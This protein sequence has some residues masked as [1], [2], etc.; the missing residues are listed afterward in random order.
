MV[1]IKKRN[2]TMTC[3]A[4]QKV[5]IAASVQHV[6]NYW[7]GLFVCIAFLLSISGSTNAQSAGGYIY[8]HEPNLQLIKQQIESGNNWYAE[9]YN[10]LIAESNKILLMDANP[11]T[12]KEY[13][14]PSGN[15]HDYLSIAPYFWPDSSKPD[16]LPWIPQDGVINPLTRG[17]NTDQ[18]RLAKL[19]DAFEHLAFAI[20][21]GNDQ[22]YADKAVS[23]IRIWFIDTATRVNPN[24]NFGQGVPGGKNGNSFGIIEWTGISKA[25]TLM[26]VLEY[27]KLLPAETKTAFAA[28]L[29]EYKDWLITSDLGIKEGRMLQNHGTWYDYQL[30]GILRY[31]GK[32][33]EAKAQAL[34]TQKRIGDQIMPDGSMPKELNRTKSVYYSEMNLRAFTLLSKMCLPLGLD[35]WNYQHQNGSSVQQA[36]HYLRPFANREKMWLYKQ[37]TPGGVDDAIDTRL[38]PLFVIANSLYNLQPLNPALAPEKGLTY[39]QR[40][41]FPF[42]SK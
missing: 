14:P 35:L 29:V 34:I 36:Y 7:L 2:C 26:Q 18:V 8:W 41:E 16:G 20:Y 38:Q 9:A 13:W 11:V 27:K 15:K 37:I 21:Y 31:L 25:I 23:L 6:R 12:A 1:S 24:I 5:F 33:E 40:L 17:N 28:W 4:N 42:Q 22:R 30:I 39:L 10:E 32:D 3:K 19:W